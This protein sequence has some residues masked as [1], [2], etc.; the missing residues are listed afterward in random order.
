MYSEYRIN[1]DAR[2]FV[3]NN[4][5]YPSVKINVCIK[6]QNFVCVYRKVNMLLFDFKYALL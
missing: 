2:R 5:V 4:N 1:L 6:C 3:K